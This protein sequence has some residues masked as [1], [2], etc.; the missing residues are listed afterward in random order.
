MC[1]H[2]YLAYERS[3]HINIIHFALDAAFERKWKIGGAV[4]GH[5]GKYTLTQTEGE[6]DQIYTQRGVD[7][8]QTTVQRTDTFHNETAGHKNTKHGTW[9]GHRRGTTFGTGKQKITEG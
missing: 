2:T 7:N 9:D 5:K 1:V 3:H 4:Y 6:S 8:D